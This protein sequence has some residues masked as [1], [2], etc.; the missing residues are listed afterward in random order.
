[1]APA[2][3][4]NR[5]CSTLARSRN[6][7][8]IAVRL[9]SSIG[10]DELTPRQPERPVRQAESGRAQRR[11]QR[12]RDGDARNHRGLLPARDAD[13]ASQTA[14]KSDQNAPD[15][16]RDS[17]A[18]SG[19]PGGQ[20]DRSHDRGFAS[21][22]E[23]LRLHGS[24]EIRDGPNGQLL[25]PPKQNSRPRPGAEQYGAALTDHEHQIHDGLE[26]EVR[27]GA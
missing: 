3:R 1:M 17:K 4:T 10:L 19:C 12:R 13:D 20:D 24:D 16:R 21:R 6:H 14:E 7:C 25:N 23:P 26:I 9:S 2:C 18:D 15:R 27:A 11:H 8:S 5:T 22:I